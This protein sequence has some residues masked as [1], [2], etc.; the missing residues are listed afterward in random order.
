MSL[1]KSY[2]RILNTHTHN[3]YHAATVLTVYVVTEATTGQA[4]YL[5]NMYIRETI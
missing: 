5:D 3:D 2:Y 1:S 4:A